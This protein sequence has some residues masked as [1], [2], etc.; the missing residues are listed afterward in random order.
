MVACLVILAA[1]WWWPVKPVAVKAPAVSAHLP[2]PNV[3]TTPPPEEAPIRAI[4]PAPPVA[5]VELPTPAAFDP[6]ADLST[7]IPDFIDLF[8]RGDLVTLAIKY[9]P[10]DAAPTDEARA[11]M[12]QLFQQKVHDPQFQQAMQQEVI[13]MQLIEN[14]TPTYDATGNQATYTPPDGS[15]PVVMVKANGRWYRQD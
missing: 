13:K 1:W 3:E 12:A 10:P 5:A 15:S 6:Q 11:A 8:Q 14:L 7:A 4:I 2:T 9:M